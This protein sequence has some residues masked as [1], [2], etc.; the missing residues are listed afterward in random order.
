MDV[1]EFEEFEKLTEGKAE[2]TIYHYKSSLQKFCDF[3]GMNP[4]ELINEAK[5]WNPED[6]ETSHLEENPADKRLKDWY[7]ELREEISKSSAATYWRNVRAFYTKFGANVR[8]ETPS[9]TYKNERPDLEASDV[10][11]IANAARSPR[12]RAMILTAF[13]GGMDPQEI[14]RLDYGQAKHGIENGESPVLVWKER[15]KSGVQHH[16]PLLKDA[17]EALRFYLSQRRKKGE[18]DDDDP[19]FTSRGGSRITAQAIRKVMRGIRDRV[20]DQIPEAQRVN[21]SINPLSLKYL[22]RAFGIAC[23][24]AKVDPVY[25]EYWMGHVEPYNGAYSGQLPIEEQKRELEKVRPYLSI[26]TPKEELKEKEKEQD[27]KIRE[28]RKENVD[29]REE[30]EELS[31]TVNRLVKPEI[32]PNCREEMESLGIERVKIEGGEDHYVEDFYCENCNRTYTTFTRKEPK[33]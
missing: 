28:L 10:R 25:K 5:N 31:R 18:L 23:R 24:K 27:E 12:D 19:L 6:S 13:Q 1:T 20:A 26:T 16:A 11:K 30:V 7:K 29:L 32:C 17:V 9:A 33:D 14:C 8:V 22:R 3:H 4:R 15:K 2:S 21:S